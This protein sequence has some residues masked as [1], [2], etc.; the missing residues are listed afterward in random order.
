MSYQELNDYFLKETQGTMTE[1]EFEEYKMIV[2]NNIPNVINQYVV[3]EYEEID[4]KIIVEVTPGLK[5]MKILN[6][7]IESGII[8]KE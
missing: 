8:Q 7:K 1:K 3:Y 2:D 6:I 5:N 4:K